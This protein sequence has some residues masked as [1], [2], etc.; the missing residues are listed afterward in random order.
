[1]NRSDIISTSIHSIIILS[2][3]IFLLLTFS[4]PVGSR[5]SLTIYIYPLIIILL[6]LSYSKSSLLL[7]AFIIGLIIDYFYQSI[8]VHSSSLVL[9]AFMR[10]YI[11]SL[12][13]PRGGYRTDNS[14]SSNNSGLSWFLMYGSIIL[15]IH[16]LTYFSVDAFSFVFLDKIFINTII[17]FIASYLIINIYQFII[18]F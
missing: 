15:F 11:L 12:L 6:P 10:P 8:G 9:I 18:R 3:Q 7:I 5:Y 4:I 1:M 13:E 17:S 2:I 14:P 16:L